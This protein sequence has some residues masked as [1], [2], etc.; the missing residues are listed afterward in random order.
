M[1][2]NDSSPPRG[3][4]TRLAT[5]LHARPI[6]AVNTSAIEREWDER[7]CDP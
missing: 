6:D 3:P 1:L 4:E 5:S 7:S 2:P